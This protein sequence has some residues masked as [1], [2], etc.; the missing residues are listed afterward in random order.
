[1]FQTLMQSTWRFV[2]ISK[3]TVA[4]LAGRAT[5]EQTIAVHVLALSVVMAGSGDIDVI[6]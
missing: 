6:Y 2:A 3:K 5:I 1:M 4:E